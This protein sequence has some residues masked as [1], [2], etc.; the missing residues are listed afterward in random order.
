MAGNNAPATSMNAQMMN[1]MSSM[2]NPMTMMMS[3]FMS[4]PQMMQQMM[5][6]FT[7]ATPSQATTPGS[8]LTTTPTPNP[9]VPA[10][11]YA[12]N[13]QSLSSIVKDKLD[14][15][16]K[17]GGESLFSTSMKTGAKYPYN[18]FQREHTSHRPQ[19]ANL[20]T[21]QPRTSSLLNQNLYRK[22]DD[23][24]K[25]LFKRG[26]A[27]NFY[28]NYDDEELYEL[29]SDSQKEVENRILKNSIEDDKK[30]DKKTLSSNFSLRI[31]TKPSI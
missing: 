16:R 31:P 22:K 17:L 6:S 30:F 19:L 18:P 2:M 24:L 26:E 4:N 20:K 9:P 10:D 12:Y 1:Q 15:S 14:N 29:K 11:S 7:G 28:D 27:R 25:F 3:M 5:Q 13:L 23:G 21:N 8:S